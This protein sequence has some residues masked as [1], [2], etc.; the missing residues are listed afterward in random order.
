MSVGYPIIEETTREREMAKT[1]E[2]TVVDY[3]TGNY[4]EF[5]DDYPN[6]YEEDDI[7]DSVMMN[8]GVE[9]KLVSDE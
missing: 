4:F 2:I 7:I 1:Y 5:T 9:V 3:H 6:D 8:V